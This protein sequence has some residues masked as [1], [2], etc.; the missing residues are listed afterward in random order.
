M[1]RHPVWRC[2]S[3][4]SKAGLNRTPVQAHGAGSL[5]PQWNAPPQRAQAALQSAAKQALVLLAQQ[6]LLHLA[7]RVARQFVH[8]EQRLGILKLAMLRFSVPTIGSPSS[9]APGL[10]TTTATHAF[11][12][13]GVRHADHRDSRRR[14]ACR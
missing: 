4:A 6:V 11:A 14:R 12:E 7:H 10:G 13:V 9:A 2:R 1:H 3:E 5:A 8:D